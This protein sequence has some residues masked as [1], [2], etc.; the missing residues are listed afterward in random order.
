[1][2]PRWLV[3]YHRPIVVVA[4]VL[5][6]VALATFLAFVFRYDLDFFGP[7]GGTW[8]IAYGTC[9]VTG[10]LITWKRPDHVMGPLFLALGLVTMLANTVSAATLGP[11]VDHPMALR[12][13]LAGVGLAA[14]T[15]AFVLLPLAIV[16]FPDGRA[17]AP[18]YNG[19]TLGLLVASGVAIVLRYRRSDAK[20]RRQ[21]RWLVL[22]VLLM[23]VAIGVV[24]V[25]DLALETPTWATSTAVEIAVLLALG[26]AIALVPISAVVARESCASGLLASLSACGRYLRRR[27]GGTTPP[28]SESCRRWSR[29]RLGIRESASIV[30]VCLA[31]RLARGLGRRCPT[32]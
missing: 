28:L 4:T 3:T 20:A 31:P 29:S 16:T 27:S 13:L 8:S 11:L 24:I 25:I 26:V 5:W 2:T 32:C 12:T 14:G 17:I 9:V 30:P 21:I 18:V 1:V 22:A 7:I 15:A 10:A 23:V 6:G 19:L